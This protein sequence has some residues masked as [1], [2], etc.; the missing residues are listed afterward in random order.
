M[1]EINC[2][3]DAKEAEMNARQAGNREMD[4]NSFLEEES[5]GKLMCKYSIPCVISLVA[6]MAAINNMIRKY[7]ALDR[8]F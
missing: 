3:A 6:A 8:I 1:S 4:T 5:L 7:G 2:Y